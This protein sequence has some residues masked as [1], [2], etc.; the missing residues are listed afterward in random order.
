MRVPACWAAV[1]AVQLGASVAP[2][3][4]CGKIVIGPDVQRVEGD[5]VTRPTGIVDGP[6]NGSAHW[7]LAEH[8]SCIG[9]EDAHHRRG[10]WTNQYDWIVGV[11]FDPEEQEHAPWDRPAR[12]DVN[13]CFAEAR[14]PCFRGVFDL[15]L[16]DGVLNNLRRNDGG[17]GD[18]GV[19]ETTSVLASE[20]SQIIQEKFGLGPLQLQY[21]AQ[22]ETPD[23]D[24]FNGQLM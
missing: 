16:S 17:H 21:Y 9:S 5:A 22:T 2:N 13:G 23:D 24:D 20:V 15:A 10:D 4:G 1:L 11:G 6:F 8:L 12:S 14:H 3:G 18:E 7:R 19:D